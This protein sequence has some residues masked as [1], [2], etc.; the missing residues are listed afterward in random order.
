MYHVGCILFGRKLLL[1]RLTSLEHVR[2]CLVNNLLICM[3]FACY[4]IL[5]DDCEIMC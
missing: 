5:K 2:Q 4:S 1:I 3:S